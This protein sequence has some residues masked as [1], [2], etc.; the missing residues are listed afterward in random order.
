MLYSLIF[1]YTLNAVSKNKAGSSCSCLSLSFQNFYETFPFSKEIIVVEVIL[2]TKQNNFPTAMNDMGQ[3]S[4]MT[5]L[6]DGTNV[7]AK[8][9]MVE[10]NRP[11]ESHGPLEVRSP[12]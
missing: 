11:I 6:K 5:P 4:E 10:V 7:E 8:S 9:P 2:L 12:F 3:P 1:L